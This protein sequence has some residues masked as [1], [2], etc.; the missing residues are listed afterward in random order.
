MAVS[1]PKTP[2]RAVGGIG[3]WWMLA[4]LFLLNVY[5]FLDR[6]AIT[7]LVPDI[8]RD[9]ALTDFEMSLILGP[10]FALSYALFGLPLGWA[11]DRFSRR[12]VIFFGTLV[13]GAAT[14]ASGLAAGF[15]HLLLARMFIGI[16]EASLAP[17]AYSLLADRFPKR[18]L[19]LAISI[20]TTGIKIGSSAALI[21]GGLMLGTFAAMSFDLPLIGRIEPWQAVFIFCGLPSLPLALLIFTFSEP[22]RQSLVDAESHAQGED[23]SLRQFIA[24]ERRLI[25]P[26]MAGFGLV[27]LLG[28]GLN[29]W[30]PTYMSRE[31]L[32]TPDQFGPALGALGFV[33]AFSLL[34]AGSLID[35]LYS[36]GVYDAHLRVYTYLLAAALP[37]GALIFFIHNPYVFLALFLVLQIAAIPIMAYVS[38]IIQL[39]TPPHLRGQMIAVFM[40][41][42][43]AIGGS[44]G[45]VVVGALTDHVFGS[46]GMLRYS[47]ACLCI[48]IVPIALALL[49]SALKHLRR[50]LEPK[51]T[52]ADVVEPAPR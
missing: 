32:W 12:W 2:Y 30:V 8:K 48:V 26:L 47:L 13:F 23:L 27:G 38:T 29:S 7:I 51:A 14:M 42:L 1:N 43:T 10:A 45:P 34:V 5:S 50:M 6:M 3:A 18:Q 19:T 49:L 9:L 4:V 28:Y 22:R 24:L 41:I 31:F 11:A 46:E 25:V 20:Y 21:V 39:I 37:V 16:G 33:S 17:G 44:V 52:P 15:V 35:Y 40:F 36:K